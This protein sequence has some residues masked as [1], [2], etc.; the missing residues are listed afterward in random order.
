MNWRKFWPSAELKQ[1]REQHAALE[2]ERGS[3]AT[4][5]RNTTAQAGS[6]QERLNEANARECKTCAELKKVVNHV[7]IAAGSRVKMFDEVGPDP[8]KPREVDLSKLNAPQG[9]QR[10]SLVARQQNDIFMQQLPKLMAEQDAEFAK[11]MESELKKD[12]V[13]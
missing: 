1:L 11:F 5:L 10:A 3:L 4:A 2:R 6:L 9:P 8:P 13:L 7:L 12:I